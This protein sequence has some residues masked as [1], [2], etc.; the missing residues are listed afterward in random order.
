[1]STIPWAVQTLAEAGEKPLDRRY[2]TDVARDGSTMMA[3]IC[4]ACAWSR[5]STEP[6]SL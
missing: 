2:H 5:P 4:D 3:A 6:R 1:M